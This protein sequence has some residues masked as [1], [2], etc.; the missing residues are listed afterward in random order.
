MVINLLANAADKQQF[1]TGMTKA[2]G[3]DKGLAVYK[4]LR[5]DYTN[6]K[7]MVDEK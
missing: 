1:Y 7:R 2:F 4:G 3:M 5:A 6:L